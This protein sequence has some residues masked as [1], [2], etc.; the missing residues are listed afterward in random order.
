MK[1]VIRAVLVSK[2]FTDQKRYYQR[3]SWPVEY[4]VRS[5]KEVGHVGFSLETT[6]T[7][8]L[9]MGQQLFEPP[10]VNGWALGPS[11]FSTAGMLARMNFASVLATNQKFELRNAAQA[12]RASPDRLVA[13]AMDSLGLP[14]LDPPVYSALVQ[15]VQAGTPWTG[16]DA[17]LLT[18]TAGLFHLLAGAGD[19]QFV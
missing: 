16:S 14:P 18:K 11:W 1:P 6:L 10:D 9:N 19:Y 5:L 2:A 15:Y 3:Y 4:V 13:F 7:P 17:Q 12:H 8:L